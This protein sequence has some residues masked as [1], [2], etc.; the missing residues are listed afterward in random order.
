MNGAN[1]HH[2]LWD[3]QRD[4]TRQFTDPAPPESLAADAA[5]SQLWQAESRW[6]HALADDRDDASLGSPEAFT[7][8]V[9]NRW[10]QP[11]TGEDADDAAAVFPGVEQ[12]FNISRTW[13]IA[14]SLLVAAWIGYL[15]GQYHE[16]PAASQDSSMVAA[17]EGDPVGI[18]MQDVNR[19]I[20]QTPEQLRRALL[21]ATAFIG[22]SDEP[23]DQRGGDDRR[24]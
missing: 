19:Q 24:S 1:D 11:V 17:T 4:H 20:T 21:S 13:G 15:A 3:E 14:A 18:L 6:L 8:A 5:A 9:L 23:A 10:R 7:A 12:P 2:E 22:G 16:Q